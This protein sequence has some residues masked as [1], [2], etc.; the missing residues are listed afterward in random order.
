MVDWGHPWIQLNH[1]DHLSSC[2]IIS[3]TYKLEIW[4]MCILKY[5]YHDK[6]SSTAGPQG[7]IIWGPIALIH[8]RFFI[9]LLIEF[10]LVLAVVQIQFPCFVMRIHQQFGKV[11]A[12]SDYNHNP[13]KA[14]ERIEIWKKQVSPI[15]LLQQQ[16]IFIGSS[17]FCSFRSFV[18]LYGPFW[19]CSVS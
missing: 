8:F 3:I 9:N 18:V 2:I 16:L 19:F 12:T 7:P 14:L 17:F 15:C 1:H 13:T 10:W 4:M 5:W 6:K 11:G